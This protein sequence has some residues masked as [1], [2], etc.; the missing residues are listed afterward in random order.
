M[1]SNRLAAPCSVN[2]AWM[3]KTVQFSYYKQTR[4]E[5]ATQKQTGGKEDNRPG[6]NERAILKLLMTTRKSIH[7]T[8]SKYVQI[9]IF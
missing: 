1:K 2:M 9:Y 4:I 5:S 6:L 8:L 3:A 7:K